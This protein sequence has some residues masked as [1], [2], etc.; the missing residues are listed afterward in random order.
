MEALDAAGGLVEV[1]TSTSKDGDRVW[2]QVGARDAPLRAQVLANLDPATG[3]VEALSPLHF[4]W[5]LAR[6]T[7]QREYHG[8]VTYSAGGE[9]LSFT[10][11]LPAIP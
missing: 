7:V 4:E 5:R 9:G 8:D 1:K 2:T 10:L 3:S 11:D 6:E